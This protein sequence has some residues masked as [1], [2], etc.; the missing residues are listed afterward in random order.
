MTGTVP[1]SAHSWR[2]VIA[3]DNPDDRAELRRLLL[4]GSSRKYDFVE[5]ETGT[6]TLRAVLSAPGGL[7]DCL[8]LDY[9]LPDFDAPALLAEL[10]GPDGLVVCPVIVV[11]GREGSDL[12]SLALR[13]GANDFIGKLWLNAPSLTRAV[14][15]TV[16]RWK[17]LRELEDS[18]TRLRLL[19]QAVPHAV[20]MTD[21]DGVTVYV[22]ERWTGYFGGDSWSVHHRMD[23]ALML[24]PED[25]PDALA[26]LAQ[27]MAEGMAFQLDCRLR[28]ADGEYRWHVVNAVPIRES[29]A[30]IT[31]WYGVNTDVHE[32]RERDARLRLGLQA[33]KIG[34]WTWEMATDAVTWTPE[35]YEIMG[36]APDA[37]DGTGRAF[38]ALVHERDRAR[39]EAT[40][41]ASIRDHAPYQ[42]EFRIVRPSG[43]VL[44]VQNQ[45][46]TAYDPSG[47]PLRMLGAVKDISQRMRA[48]LALKAREREMRTLADNI[49]AV[50]ARFDHQL[51]HVFIN[52]AVE[53][54]T[55][56][57]PANFLGKTNRELGMP[58]HL[59]D[60]WE[61]ALRS[62]IESAEPKVIEFEYLSGGEPH[63]FSSCLVPELGP[64]GRVEFV[65]SVA[66]DVTERKKNDAAL[67]AALADAEDAIRSRDQLASLVSH[68]LKNPLNN[69]R[70]SIAVL[71]A[72]SPGESRELLSKMTRQ[73]HRMDGMVEELLDLAELQS[74]KRISLELNEVDLIE[75]V[76][77]LVGEH[78]QLAR[79]HR[80]ELQASADSVIGQWDK[81]RI[82]RVVNNL[83]A[84][85]I[86]YSPGGGKVKIGVAKVEF[87]GEPAAE[88]SVTDF[89]IGVPDEDQN[90]VFQWYSRGQN[91]RDT[92]VTGHGIGL[93]GAR[94]IV[95]QHGG[96]IK[97]K[98]VE[99]QGS[100]FTVILPL[101][102]PAVSAN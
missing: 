43:E 87:G 73:I 77:S 51:R 61:G 96:T 2:V 6:Q 25:A 91:A 80:L 37:F 44:W 42:A 27:A 88:L 55:G 89:G 54:L 46:E 97:V 48:D 67:R 75:V 94:D 52:S 57:A 71:E 98:S 41:K 65:L 30:F 15:N 83:L 39:V 4:Q 26:R 9:F 22:N 86:K 101:H 64:D 70:L 12:G 31:H 50:V 58:A 56:C 68:D 32:L 23:W 92:Q 8:V 90:R 7:P 99:G 19:A 100:T 40:V 53:K 93:A 102:P 18:K 69:L 38:F 29:A 82:D 95:V 20:W 74:G 11:T 24:H 28:R 33:S 3:D 5:V 78:Q 63:F 79:R 76:K 14:E 35:A 47:T 85:A 21:G 59:C 36:V 49:P 84:N 16:T 17:I 13:A 72:A 66:D 60:L 10:R 1:L 45:G 34:L 62:V 81:R